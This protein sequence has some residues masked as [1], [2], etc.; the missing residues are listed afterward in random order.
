[1]AN[2]EKYK[3]LFEEVNQLKTSLQEKYNVV[4]NLHV[5][6][7]STISLEE[8]ELSV[9]SI[10]HRQYPSLRTFDLKDKTRLR[11]VVLFRSIFYQF[12]KEK[13]YRLKEMTEH[14]RQNHATAIHGMRTLE[15]LLSIND[16]H[17]VKYFHM[18]KEVMDAK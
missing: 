12:A 15:Q 11:P 5:V 3:S 14:I 10:M 6:V 18:V 8:I 16:F 9:T 2:T 13:G 7:L 1:M 4:I 17:A